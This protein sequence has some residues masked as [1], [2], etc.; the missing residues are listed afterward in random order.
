MVGPMEYKIV[1]YIPDGDP[2]AFLTKKS[3]EGWEY[4]SGMHSPYHNRTVETAE[5]ARGELLTHFEC[6]FR[7]PTEES[8]PEWI[9]KTD[10]AR[11]IHQWLSN[12]VPSLAQRLTAAFDLKGPD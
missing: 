11:I 12:P 8:G 4:V 2:A 9:K 3:A 5:H 6:V 10:V 1:E 7:R